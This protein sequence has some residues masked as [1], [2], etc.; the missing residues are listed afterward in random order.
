MRKFNYET[1]TD[2]TKSSDEKNPNIHVNNN[3]A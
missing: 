3:S 1:Q 2:F